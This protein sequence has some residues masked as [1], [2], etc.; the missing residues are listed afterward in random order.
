MCKCTYFD[1]FLKA[2]ISYK[3]LNTTRKCN[4]FIILQHKLSGL[5]KSN[6]GQVNMFTYIRKWSFPSWSIIRV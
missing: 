3:A 2:K 6:V 5:R 4:D 1:L